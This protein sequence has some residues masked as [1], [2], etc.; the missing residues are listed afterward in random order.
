MLDE[1]FAHELNKV[2]LSSVNIIS[3]F[4]HADRK[5]IDGKIRDFAH[6]KIDILNLVNPSQIWIVITILR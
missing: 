4:K 5:Y 3:Y 1:K 2:S 6:K